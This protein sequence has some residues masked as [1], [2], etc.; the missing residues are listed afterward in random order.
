M[1]TLI[2]TFF[3]C[4]SE[5]DMEKIKGTW[6]IVE[7]SPEV[8][9]LSPAIIEGA[10]TEA[11]SCV[12]TFREDSTFTIVSNFSPNGDEGRFEFEEEKKLLKLEYQAKDGN[13]KGTYKII[14]LTDD[15]MVWEEAIAS[16]GYV[17]LTLKKNNSAYFAFKL[18]VFTAIESVFVL[19]LAGF[20]SM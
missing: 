10:K 18:S 1:T 19:S 13:T 15:T 4:S 12:Y 6:E 9:D 2:L 11:L 16:F 20:L 17:K 7:F 5:T 3:G 8:S 14:E